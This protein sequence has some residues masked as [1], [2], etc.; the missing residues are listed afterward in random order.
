MDMIATWA[1]KYRKMTI[2]PW[3]PKIVGDGRGLT[4]ITV[5]TRHHL[6]G[7]KDAKRLA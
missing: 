2:V 5:T 4:I 3:G 7:V 6:V 1:V